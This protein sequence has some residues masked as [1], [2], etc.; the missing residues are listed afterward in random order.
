M[1]TFTKAELIK[2]IQAERSRF[3][4]AI[5]GLSEAQMEAPGA[6]AEWSVKDIAAHLMFWQQRAVFLLECARDGWQPGK[7]RW[8]GSTLF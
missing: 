1:D 2:R 6:E 4:G 5:S 7:D 8:S 3:S